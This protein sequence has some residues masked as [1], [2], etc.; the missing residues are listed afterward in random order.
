MTA[1][2]DLQIAVEQSLPA[3]AMFQ[4]WV[5]AAIGDRRNEAELTLRITDSAEVQQLNKTYRDKDQ[6]TNVLSFPADLP[7]ELNIPL[8]GDIIIS[9]EVV[10]QEAL[11]QGKSSEAH[12]AHMVIHGTLHLLGYDHID[13]N[14][15]EAME[16]LETQLL[17]QLGYP[18]PYHN[19]D[20]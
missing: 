5:E 9:A 8:L 10:E 16:S 17:S 4:R 11:E 12:W 7:P 18:N 6:S 19:D 14:D 15:A 3:P 20:I 13:D 1:D 2:L